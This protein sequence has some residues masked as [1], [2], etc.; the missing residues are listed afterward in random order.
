MDQRYD[1]AFKSLAEDD[2]RALLHLLGSLPADVA[3]EVTPVER[4]I[5]PRAF[6]VDHAYRI[7]AGG[8]EWIVILEALTHWTAEIL[9]RLASYC[10]GLGGVSGLPVRCVLALLVEDHAPRVVPDSH[11]VAKHR[12]ARMR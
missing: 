10:Y 2:P 6:R 3:A 7:R 12:H 9:P 4:E 5:V 1:K 11:R 8:D